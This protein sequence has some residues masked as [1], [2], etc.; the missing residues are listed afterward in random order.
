MHTDTKKSANASNIGCENAQLVSALNSDDPGTQNIGNVFTNGIPFDLVNAAFG[1]DLASSDVQSKFTPV[2][3]GSNSG[4]EECM[5][6]CNIKPQADPT[7][8]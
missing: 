7:K 3:T 4:T 2:G 6:R 1:Q 8:L 5:A